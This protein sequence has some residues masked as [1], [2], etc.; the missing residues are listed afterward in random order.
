[1]GLSISSFLVLE[2]AFY[3]II[4]LATSTLG[5]Y[6]LLHKILWILPEKCALAIQRLA[7]TFRTEAVVVAEAGVEVAGPLGLVGG[8]LV[9]G[10][11]VMAAGMMQAG[12][13]VANGVAHVMAICRDEAGPV[14]DSS[15]LP[16]SSLFREHLFYP[17][18]YCS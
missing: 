4:T 5:Y 8:A 10:V 16:S 2:I 3:C 13:E 15:K 17:Y 14:E 7:E 12:A 1:M 9:R 6:G 18:F 11:I